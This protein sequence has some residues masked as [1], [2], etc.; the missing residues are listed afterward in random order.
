VILTLAGTHL[1][2]LPSH[3]IDRGHYD[4][5]LIPLQPEKWSLK[6]QFYV[7]LKQPVDSLSPAARAFF[8]ELHQ[9]ETSDSN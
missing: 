1:S 4:Q 7:V 2:F 9:L 5:A 8:D 3:L 6:S